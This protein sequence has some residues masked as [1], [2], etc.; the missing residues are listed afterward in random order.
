M[1]FSRIKCI[2][3]IIKQRVSS[4]NNF[5]ALLAQLQQCK[6][7]DEEQNIIYQKKYEKNKTETIRNII[8]L[9]VKIPVEVIQEFGMS[10]ESQDPW[11]TIIGETKLVKKQEYAKIL[12]PDFLSINTLPIRDISASLRLN[13]IDKICLLRRDHIFCRQ[14]TYNKFHQL[15]EKDFKKIIIFGKLGIGKTIQFKYLSYLWACNQWET[16][17]NYLLLTVSLSIVE[18]DDDVYDAILK[19]NFRQFSYM[20]KDVVKLMMEEKSDEIILFF[21]QVHDLKEKESFKEFIEYQNPRIKTVVWTRLNKIEDIQYDIS[22]ELIGFN[23]DQLEEFLFKFISREASTIKNFSLKLDDAEEK[24]RYFSQIPLFSLCLFIL[25]AKN[26]TVLSGTRYFL[27]SKII[28]LIKTKIGNLLTT[29]FMNDIKEQCCKQCH[30]NIIILTI[31]G[32]KRS[33]I[34]NINF[35]SIIQ[36]NKVSALNNCNIELEFCDVSFKEYFIAEFI[37]SLYEKSSLRNKINQYFFYIGVQNFFSIMNFIKDYSEEIY[38][39]ITNHC[40]AA[41]A[42]Y[43]LDGK[44]KELI[45]S[46][47]EL[48]D[49][50]L[51]LQTINDLSIIHGIFENRSLLRNLK[52]KIHETNLSVLLSALANSCRNLEY[53][54]INWLINERNITS[55][56]NESIIQNLTKLIVFDKMKTIKLSRTTIFIDKETIELKFMFTNDKYKRILFEKLNNIDEINSDTYLC[57]N[58]ETLFSTCLQVFDDNWRIKELEVCDEN[59][60]SATQLIKNKKLE[61]ITIKNCCFSFF[62]LKE[63]LKDQECLI[64]IK[65][66]KNQILNVDLYNL[67]EILQT[68]KDTLTELYFQNNSIQSNAKYIDENEE[69]LINL[70]NEFI[71]LNNLVLDEV[72]CKYFG[73]ENIIFLF[74]KL[75]LQISSLN[76]SSCDI[77]YSSYGNMVSILKNPEYILNIDYSNNHNLKFGFFLILDM[78]RSDK[79]Q[80]KKVDFSNCNLNFRY[81]LS[82]KVAFDKYRFIEEI[83]FSNNVNLNLGCLNLLQGLMLSK[84][85]LKAINFS[86]CGLNNVAELEMKTVHSQF[87]FIQTVDYSRN[88]LKSVFFYIMAGLSNSGITLKKLNF[89]NCGISFY[90]KSFNI[91]E[92]FSQFSSLEDINLSENFITTDGLNQILNGLKNCSETLK[93]INFANSKLIDTNM[94]KLGNSLSIFREIR[95][96]NF[97]GNTFQMSG[98][99]NILQ[100]LKNCQNLFKINFSNCHLNFQSLLNIDE[101]LNQF[102]SMKEVHFNDNTGL[103]FGCLKILDGLDGC[104][105]TLRKIKFSNCCVE[106]HIVFQVKVALTKF[107]NISEIDFSNNCLQDGCFQIL[108]GLN[109]SSKTLRKIDFSDCKLDDF[110]NINIESI[111]SK[112]KFIESINFS[113][114]NLPEN[115]FLKIIQGL[116]E[117]KLTLQTINF[118]DCGINY[119]K[120]NAAIKDNL[121]NFIS[122]KEV[123]FNDNSNL[124]KIFTDIIGGLKNCRSLKKIHFSNCNLNTCNEINQL[125]SKFSFLEDINF[126]NNP[127]PVG[128]EILNNLSNCEYSL[129]K[130]NYFDCKSFNSPYHLSFTYLLHFKNLKSIILSLPEFDCSNIFMGFKNCCKSL[131]TLSLSHVVYDNVAYENFKRGLT[132]FHALVEI[133]VNKS[134]IN[135]ITCIKIL[136]GLEN[137]HS[138]LKIINFSSCGMDDTNSNGI[139]RVLLRFSSVEHVN[140]SHNHLAKNGFKEIIQGL[141]NCSS[142][143]RSINFS[144]CNLKDSLFDFDS[145]TKEYL[146]NF[147]YMEEVC[148]EN[149]PQLN[150]GCLEIIDGLINSNN[151]LTTINFS[152]CGLQDFRNKQIKRLLH[153]FRYIEDVNFSKNPLPNFGCEDILDGLKKSELSLRRIN[154]SECEL[155]FLNT[156]NIQDKIKIFSSI[157]EINFGNNKS[158]SFGCI[159]LIKGLRDSKIVLK[160]LNFSNCSLSLSDAEEIKRIL[161]P[162]TDYNL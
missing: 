118:S 42:K 50:S 117:S 159:E 29:E 49:F 140:F 78:L 122:I 25:F 146:K 4:K 102:Q 151:S 63:L 147:K 112:F 67:L 23:R 34:S 70:F 80:L 90:V 1:A 61:K 83:N 5:A 136:S 19:Q 68:S 20:T 98:C 62:N 96:I 24:L 88:N 75:K 162:L 54:E 103:K 130:I 33:L 155:D 65:V 69:N 77:K 36:L 30:K 46:N 31:N 6:V 55:Q 113:R 57:I 123:N 39:Y 161:L 28:E 17:K 7:I 94:E 89:S 107:V 120:N 143:L 100:G 106:R 160:K 101:V 82:T 131:H 156:S 2:I 16:S 105:S 48:K 43:N 37:I 60:E 13:K 45:H 27:Y 138:T 76:F 3:Y 115:G 58:D 21:D 47:K 52:V 66:T 8:L 64:S 12:F 71:N 142:S 40:P 141:S 91:I 85:T 87:R 74:S 79:S 121:V 149:N 157:E 127:L 32:D 114:N 124:P 97:S 81:G 134:R 56:T 119:K 51:D 72:V 84:S 135:F 15:F 109:S 18:K 144:S 152:D 38:M 133:N 137:C 93:I 128:T 41:I 14:L 10:A 108:N 154:F 116:K 59:L 132:Q 22:Y 153:N 11:I 125:F 148:F 129:R 53:L 92:T 158:L 126:S 95:D 9:L 145:S 99:I 139:E 86:N 35:L 73:I 26:D 150:I 104:K 44:I 110:M 111:L